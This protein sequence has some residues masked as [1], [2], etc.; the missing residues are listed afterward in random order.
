MQSCSSSY[1]ASFLSVASFSSTLQV[2]PPNLSGWQTL[3]LVFVGK[4]SPF[5]RQFALHLLQ[6]EAQ[7]LQAA[8]TGHCLRMNICKDDQNIVVIPEYICILSVFVSTGLCFFVFSF[9]LKATIL[10]RIAFPR[11]FHISWFFITFYAGF[12]TITIRIP[13]YP[14]SINNFIKV[15]QF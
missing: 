5:L 3:D 6:P 2:F 14:C 12:G 13:L 9:A 1:R 15:A 7:A 11:S 4:L 8:S 10:R